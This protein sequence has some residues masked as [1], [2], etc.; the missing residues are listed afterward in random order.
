LFRGARAS[1]FTV[2]FDAR[3]LGYGAVKII[4]PENAGFFL[5]V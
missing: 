1:I 5:D 3:V 4:T 2:F